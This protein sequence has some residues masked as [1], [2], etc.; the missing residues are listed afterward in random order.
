MVGLVGGVERAPDEHDAGERGQE[1]INGQDGTSHVLLDNGASGDTFARAYKELTALDPG[2]L[3]SNTFDAAVALELATFAAAHA[4]PDP[5]QVT[6]AQVRDALRTINDPAG[7]LIRTGPDEMAKAFDLLAEGKPINFEGA[8]G[9]VDFDAN[10][11]VRGRIAHW[12]VSGSRFTDLRI[13]DCVASNE[14]PLVQ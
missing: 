13:Y 5:T 3:D 12:Q 10:G 7:T 6:G 1:S 14:C 4:L 9:P 8:S 2:F 11:N